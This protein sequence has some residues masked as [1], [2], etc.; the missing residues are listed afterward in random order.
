MNRFLEIPKQGA[1]CDIVWAD[2]CEQD[3]DAISTTY[4]ENSTR[5]CSYVFGLKAVKPFLVKN[6]LVSIFRAHE[7][8]LE[9]FKMHKWEKTMS[10]PPV[11]TIFSAPNYCDVYNNKG[12]ILKLSNNTLNLQ[13]FNYS[14]HPYIL[15]GFQNIFNWSI[16]FISEKSKFLLIIYKNIFLYD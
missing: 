16:P 7:A 5:G 6:K 11:I 12:S 10:F 15:P 2:P 14:P 3:V 13:Q 1:L 8:Q 9:G 4:R